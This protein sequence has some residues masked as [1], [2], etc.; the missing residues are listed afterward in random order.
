MIIKAN[1]IGH[2]IKYDSF[3]ETAQASHKKNE[4]IANAGINGKVFL[5]YEFNG[6]ELVI[7]T[8]NS[9]FLYILSDNGSITWRAGTSR[10]SIVHRTLEDKTIFQLPSGRKIS[11]SWKETLDKFIGKQFAI[12]SSDQDLFIFWRG[13]AEHKISLLKSISSNDFYLILSET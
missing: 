6:T 5:S 3:E 9:N 2:P 8:D 7:E 1:F 4:E 12:S 13:G 10:P 11:W